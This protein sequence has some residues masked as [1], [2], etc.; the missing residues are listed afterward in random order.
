[1]KEWNQNSEKP[2]IQK[3][4]GKLWIERGFVGL[5]KELEQTAGTFSVG[6]HVTLADLFLGPQVRNAE[7]FGVDMKQ[8]PT[9]SRIASTLEN[10]PE[11]EA[12]HPFHQPDA[13]K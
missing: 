7:R 1:M 6:D 5:E 4:W 12:T 8:F 3:E 10:L 13:E 9:I 11:F 2:G